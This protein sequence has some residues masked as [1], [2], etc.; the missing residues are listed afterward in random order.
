MVSTS[1]FRIPKAQIGV[2]SGALLRIVSR[3][4]FGDEVPDNA[5]VY[6]H[7]LPVLRA[8]MSFS[9]RARRWRRLDRTLTAYAQLG[10]AGVIGCSWC[11]DFGRY[12]AHQDGLDLVRLAEVPRWRESDMFTPLERDVL[13]YAEAM[14]LTP[15]TVTDGLVERLITALG[16]AAV[17]E[18]TQI[19]ALENMYSRF[20][21]AAGLHSQGY[22]QVCGVTA[23]VAPSS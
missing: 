3:R 15:P 19:I 17:V 7:H 11:L 2:V 6:L 10:A 18:L 8:V 16:P 9:G 5:Y 14:S 12:Q 1:T 23:A 21:S 13:E 22:A 4:Q 20:N